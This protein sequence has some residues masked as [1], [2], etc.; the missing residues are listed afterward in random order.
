MSPKASGDFVD[1]LRRNLRDTAGS[2]NIYTRREI[3]DAVILSQREARGVFW[4]DAVY[5][6]L[7]VSPSQHNYT[8]PDYIRRINRVE[9]VMSEGV[10]S[11]VDSGSFRREIIYDWRHTPEARTNRLWIGGNFSP[12]A[13]AIHYEADLP[14][15]PIEDTLTTGVTATARIIPF[16][17][18]ASPMYTW[19][20]PGY[21]KIGNEIMGYEAVTLTSFTGVTRGLFGTGVATATTPFGLRQNSETLIQPA[22]AHEYYQSYDFIIKRSIQALLTQ[23]LLGND[24]E[25]NKVIGAL[26]T[27]W[28]RAA[29]EARNRDRQ[30]RTAKTIQMKRRPRS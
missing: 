19:P 6:S 30:R 21:L 5:D 9:R 28:G 22:V 4:E 15:F 13:L 2:N 12:S 23:R 17:N 26:A 11:Q 10:Q 16:S 24:T 18:S 27:E 3:L 14:I 20:I 8:L 29:V 25:G 7:Q 1:E